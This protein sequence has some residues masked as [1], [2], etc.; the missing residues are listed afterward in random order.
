MTKSLWTERDCVVP[1][2]VPKLSLSQTPAGIL[3]QYD[4]EYERNGD[5]RRRAYFL[6]PNLKRIV[7]GQKPIFVDPGKVGP[8]KEI[9]LLRSFPLNEPRPA[10]F[11]VCSSNE[12]VFSLYRDGKVLGP[13]DLPIFKDGRETAEQVALTPLAV[14]GDISIV[15]YWT[16]PFWA[17]IF[18]SR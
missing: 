8:Q 7:A 1:S 6:E 10:L 2:P 18:S 16:A 17:Q 12:C 4:L 5:I 15:G 3:V 13:C 11:A 14:T 9:P